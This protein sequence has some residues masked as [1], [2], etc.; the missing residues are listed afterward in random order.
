MEAAQ[1]RVIVERPEWRVLAKPAGW[2]TLAHAG[3]NAERSSGEAGDAGGD[4]GP[5][6]AHGSLEAWL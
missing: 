1:P 4:A 6:A 3:G 5:G 2:H